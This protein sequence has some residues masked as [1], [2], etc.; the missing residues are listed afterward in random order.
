VSSSVSVVEVERLEAGLAEDFE[1][2]VEVA[3]EI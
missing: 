1:V 2:G 3:M